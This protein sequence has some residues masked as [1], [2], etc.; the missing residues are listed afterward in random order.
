MDFNNS[1]K[2]WKLLL[3]IL[4]F[5]FCI[6]GIVYAQEDSPP[7]TPGDEIV[8]EQEKTFIELL[9]ENVLA[10]TIVLIFFT[11]IINAFIKQRSR[12]KCLKDFKDYN[13][14]FKMKNGKAIWGK[15]LLYSNGLELLY[16]QPYYDE[17]DGHYEYSYIFGESEFNADIQAIHRYHWDL[18]PKNKKRRERSIK[19]SYNPS[20]FRRIGRGMRNVVNTLKDAFNKSMKLFI[21]Q[22]GG[23]IA[24]GKATKELTSVGGSLIGAMGNAY[25]SILEKYIGRKVIAEM[26]IGDKIQEYEGILKEY[27]ANYIE[28]LNVKYTFDFDV[29]V[30]KILEN[31]EF[32]RI[33]FKKINSTTIEINNPTPTPVEFVAIE[34]DDDYKKEISKTIAANDVLKFDISEYSDA[35]NPR[36]ILKTKRFVDIIAPRNL[37]K[38]RHSGKKDKMSVSELL[39]LDDITLSFINSDKTKA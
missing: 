38:I 1:K 18:T 32:S 20:L 29:N 12:D 23:K 19:V 39:G 3:S 27:T 26:L 14:T 9:L 28:L 35:K 36:L 11:A 10:I 16:K 31:D 15:L 13:V 34:G 2:A 21:G 5:V 4:L 37:I 8:I 24:G 25:D 33:L 22:F 30:V 17:S 7:G 6:T